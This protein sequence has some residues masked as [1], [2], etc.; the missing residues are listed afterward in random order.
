M[1][2]GLLAIAAWLSLVLCLAPVALW[3]RGLFVADYLQWTTG[4]DD[5]HNLWAFNR[6][7]SNDFH[8]LWIFNRGG[9][10]S[11]WD[12]LHI[13]GHGGSGGGA[14]NVPFGRHFE[15]QRDSDTSYPKSALTFTR[16][17]QGGTLRSWRHFG[18]EFVYARSQF[19]EYG[20]LDRT[21]SIVLPLPLLAAFL[22]VLPALVAKKCRMRCASCGYSLTGNT[23]GIC[24]ECGTSIIGGR[25]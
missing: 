11:V 12:N 17:F 20:F 1:K 21:I 10:L 2:R 18:I 9:G 6:S 14:Y 8:K 5:I 3:I 13:Q 15:W 7:W 19:A 24:P 4:Y 25:P 16:V 23:T 22:A